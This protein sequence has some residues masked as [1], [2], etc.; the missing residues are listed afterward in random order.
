MVFILNTIFVTSNSANP[1]GLGCHTRQC[2]NNTTM[3][4]VATEKHS[5]RNVRVRHNHK[6]RRHARVNIVRGVLRRD[7]T[8]DVLAS[9]NR[10]K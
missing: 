10:K 5:R 6:A 1:E 8:A 3:R 9:L 7:C 2:T 4:Q